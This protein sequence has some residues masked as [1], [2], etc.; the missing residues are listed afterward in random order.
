MNRIA[1]T[2]ELYFFSEQLFVLIK[3]G[4]TL[5][6]EE[7]WNRYAVE[8]GEKNNPDYLANLQKNG[9]YEKPTGV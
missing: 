2:D 9:H 5:D 6:Y 7:Y 1:L 8:A 3:G 4:G